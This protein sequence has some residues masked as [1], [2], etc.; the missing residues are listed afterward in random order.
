[1]E[2]VGYYFRR[3]VRGDWLG[4]RVAYHPRF[5]PDLDD[6]EEIVN[7]NW[8]PLIPANIGLSACNEHLHRFGPDYKITNL[9]YQPWL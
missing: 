9:I 4:N 2:K 7:D 1:M 3:L 6:D 5:L 8:R